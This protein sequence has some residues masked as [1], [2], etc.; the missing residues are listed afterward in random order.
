MVKNK[1]TSVSHWSKFNGGCADAG[2]G[3]IGV[4][5]NSNLVQVEKMVT[6]YMKAT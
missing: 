5:F 6:N 1:I 4:S 2:G 3:G